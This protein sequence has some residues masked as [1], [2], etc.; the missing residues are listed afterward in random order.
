[1]RWVFDNWDLAGVTQF[2][3][4]APLGISYSFVSA[5]DVVGG[6]GAGVDSRVNVVQNPVI[7]K[8]ERNEYRAFNTGAFAPP[9]RAENG[10]GN[11]PKDVFRGPGINNFDVSFY[12][13]IPFDRDGKRRLQFRFEF[14]NFFN[15]ASFGGPAGTGV[16]TAARFDAAGRQVSGTFGQYTSTLDARRTVI[17]AKFYF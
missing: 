14:Y 9:T 16:D 17:G 11:A 6:G 12:K 4:G 7:P 8:S 1:M 15:H 5:V 2:T 13:T 10:I 3:S